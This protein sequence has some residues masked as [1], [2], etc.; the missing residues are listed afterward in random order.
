ME[1]R[2]ICSCSRMHLLQLQTD[3]HKLELEPSRPRIP[4]KLLPPSVLPLLGGPAGRWGPYAAVW[5]PLGPLCLVVWLGMIWACTH[6][7]AQLLWSMLAPSWALSG[8]G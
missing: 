6:M 7:V 4:P 1:L 5:W 3:R 8:E 2:F